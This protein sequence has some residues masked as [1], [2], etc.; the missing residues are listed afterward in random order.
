MVVY[1]Y[2]HAVYLQRLGVNMHYFYGTEQ[3][4]QVAVR[5][6]ADMPDG[7]YRT[8]TCNR[9]SIERATMLVVVRRCS[10]LQRCGSRY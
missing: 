8:Q 3:T 4:C 6:L 1:Y 10:T 9:R 2:I 5:Q 7:L